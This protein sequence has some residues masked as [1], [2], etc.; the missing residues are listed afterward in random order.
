MSGFELDFCSFKG[1]CIKVNIPF[2]NEFITLAQKL[3]TN[4]E[5]IS[6]SILWGPRQGNQQNLFKHPTTRIR[7]RKNKEMGRENG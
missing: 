3:G 2:Q 4:F 5:Q 7:I 6:Y 1:L